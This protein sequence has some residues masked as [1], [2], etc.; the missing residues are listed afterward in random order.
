MFPKLM[1]FIYAAV[2]VLGVALGFVVAVMLVL[3]MT[4]EV[5]AQGACVTNTYFVEGRMVVCQTCCNGNNC[6]TVCF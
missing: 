6:N 1:D 2:G 4:K 5:C 3:L